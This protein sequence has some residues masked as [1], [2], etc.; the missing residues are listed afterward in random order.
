MFYLRVLLILGVF[1]SVAFS[2]GD[3]NMFGFFQARYQ[4]ITSEDDFN[5]DDE[6]TFQIQQLN[7]MGSKDLGSGFNAFINFEILN[8][9]DAERGIGNFNLQEAFVNWSN[10]DGSLQLKIGRFL[11]RFNNLYEIYNRTPLLPYA[12]RPL[13]YERQVSAIIDFEDWLPALGNFQVYGEYGLTNSLQL[14]YAGFIGNLE[15]AIMDGY[16]EDYSI[17]L[18]R[19]NGSTAISVGG[20]VGLG[21]NSSKGGALKIGASFAIDKDNAEQINIY[22]KGNFAKYE[23]GSPGEGLQQIPDLHNGLVQLYNSVGVP[24]PENVQALDSRYFTNQLNLGL[25]NRTKI[26]A[27]FSYSNWGFT[28]SGE[29]IMTTYSIDESKKALL[30]N[31]DDELETTFGAVN[32][33]VDAN[34]TAYQNLKNADRTQ[35]EETINA[36]PGEQGDQLRA[37]YNQ[38][39]QAL[40]SAPDE[41]FGFFGDSFDKMFYFVTLQYD[42]TDDIY[43]YGMTSSISADEIYYLSDGLTN[44]SGGAGYKPVPFVVLKAQYSTFELNSQ[45]GDYLDNNFMLAVSVMF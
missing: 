43:V 33:A 6:N 24:L 35:L 41:L 30:G 29:F 2:Q 19:G 13:V 44:Y 34:Q 11:P 9:Y 31:G 25:L 1:S 28:L 18:N 17:A 14:Q 36:I 42:I 8:D 37:T 5:F 27:D 3:L 32:Q 20:R 21:Y 10:Y 4:N 45:G 39:N 38:L 16:S 26:G 23:P 22:E 7:L 40:S 15:N 12:Y